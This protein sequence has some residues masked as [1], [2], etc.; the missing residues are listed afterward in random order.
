MF[1]RKKSEELF[2][3]H[4]IMLYKVVYKQN[5]YLIRLATAQ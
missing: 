4:F 2:I 1:D 3:P 5:D